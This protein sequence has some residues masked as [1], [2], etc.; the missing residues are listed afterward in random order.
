[1]NYKNLALFILINMGTFEIYGTK[2]TQLQ[3]RR[4]LIGVTGSIAAIEVPH[5]VREIIRY[6]GDPIVV[7]SNEATRLVAKDALTWCMDKEPITTISG[8]SEHIKWIAHPDFKVDL[9]IMCPAT[10]NSISKLANG[11]ADG[12]VTLTALAAFG[13]GIPILIVPAAHTVLLDNPITERN[14]KNLKEQN[15]YFLENV[16]EENKYKFPP[17]QEFMQKIFDLIEPTDSILFGKKFLITGGA[18]REYLDDV[19]F[20]SNPSTGLSA[21][22]IAQAL[23]VRGALVKLI[24][25]EGNKLS[26]KAN[27]ETILVSSTE[28]MYRKV[29]EELI[30]TSYDGFISVAAVSDY[31][32]SYQAGK[33]PSKKEKLTIELTPTIKIIEKIKQ[34]FPELYII[35]FKAEVGIEKEELIRRGR[36]LLDKY[37]LQMVCAN[38]VGEP[39]KGFASETNELIVIRDKTSEMHLKGSKTVLGQKITEIIAQEFKKRSDIS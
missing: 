16:E 39:E 15:V 19:R 29:R 3:G 8:R 26:F 14:I 9:Y 33:I 13:A 30:N 37:K 35:A 12:P 10:A 4:L 2:G 27:I 11:I 38:W 22:R 36:E 1:M 6:S 32:P 23:Q 21:L 17:L 5:L 7:L 20:L 24:L 18:T 25:G 28:E 31:K 34:E